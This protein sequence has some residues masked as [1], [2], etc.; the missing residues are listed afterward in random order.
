MTDENI[1]YVN[2]DYSE[3]QEF[4]AVHNSQKKESDQREANYQL[5]QWCQLR[6][7]FFSSQNYNNFTNKVYTKMPI[8]SF[9]FY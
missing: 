8:L 4:V 1:D 5:Q 6:C 3:Q 7:Y 9:I 2:E